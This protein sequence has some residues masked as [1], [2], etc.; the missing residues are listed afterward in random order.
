MRTKFDWHPERKERQREE[1]GCSEECKVRKLRRDRG[2][3]DKGK[4]I[5]YRRWTLQ[6]FSAKYYI[7]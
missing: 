2:L 1:K 3:E 5:R 7:C 6:Y 4:Y